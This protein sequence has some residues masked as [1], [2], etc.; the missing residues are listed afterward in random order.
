MTNTPKS[1]RE[2]ITEGRYA[3][4]VPYLLPPMAPIDPNTTT[5]TEAERRREAYKAERRAQQRLHSE[6]DSRLL[7][8]F[9]ADLEAEY[10]LTGHPK[11]G[12]LWSLAYAHGHSSG[13]SEIL[14][15]YDE[16]S[17]LVR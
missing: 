11:A 17:E 16:L 12:L 13:Y 2:Y 1:V 3:N 10:G 4:K 8:L 6:E 9:Q 15:W 5:I 7:A 14:I